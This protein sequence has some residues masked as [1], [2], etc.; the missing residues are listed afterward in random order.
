[1]GCARWPFC[2]SCCSTPTYPDFPQVLGG[3]FLCYLRY[4]ITFILLRSLDREEFSLADFMS[5]AFGASC[6]PWSPCPLSR[7]LW[8]SA[9]SRRATAIVRQE[10]GRDRSFLLKLSFLD[11]A[12]IFRCAGKHAAVVAYLVTRRG[13]AVLHR[14]ADRIVFRLSAQ[15]DAKRSHYS[16]YD[17]AD[18]EPGL[19]ASKSTDRRRSVL[20]S[21]PIP[22]MELMI[23]ALLAL[24]V[25]PQLSSRW[26][27]DLTSLAGI[28]MIVIASRCSMLARRFQVCGRSSR[29]S[30]LCL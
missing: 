3:R 4:L 1:M 21:S 28:V 18:R 6:P 26:Q 25:F 24:G 19:C 30:A 27:R 7:R 29:A 12:W 10:F 5:A 22:R 14:M 15:V 11:F 8:R 2:R 16:R 17:F 23:G 13:G 9:C 20:L